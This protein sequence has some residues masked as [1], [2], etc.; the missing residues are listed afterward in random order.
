MDVSETYLCGGGA[1]LYGGSA[2]LAMSCS[3]DIAVPGCPR[4]T[5]QTSRGIP[6][7]ANYPGGFRAHEAGVGAVGPLDVLGG[8]GTWFCCIAVTW[9]SDIE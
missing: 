5:R 8:W 2:V 9:A 4:R 3:S 1:R 6:G 7:T